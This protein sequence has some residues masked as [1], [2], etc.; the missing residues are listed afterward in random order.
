MH[1]HAYHFFTLLVTDFPNIAPKYV[2][3]LPDQ[4]RENYSLTTQLLLS[5]LC[6]QCLTL[7]VGRH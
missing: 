5:L 1:M 4:L 3:W 2:Q 6:H 7:L